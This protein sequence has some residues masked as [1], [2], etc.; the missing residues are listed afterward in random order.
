MGIV[1]RVADPGSPSSIPPPKLVT[2]FHRCC[3]GIRWQ[4][5]SWLG[6][7]DNCEC[8]KTEFGSRSPSGWPASS[9]VKKDRLKQETSQ[10]LL[11]FPARTSEAA[12]THDITFNGKQEVT[13]QGDPLGFAQNTMVKGCVRK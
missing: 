4:S 11:L 5:F 3:P 8:R 6:K 1:V 2:V 12:L 13:Y 10:Q 7:G 9:F